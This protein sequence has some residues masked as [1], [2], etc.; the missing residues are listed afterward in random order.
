MKESE[1]KKEGE[2]K[3]NSEEKKK[4]ERKKEGKR[5]DKVSEECS[6]ENNS[7]REKQRAC[8]WYKSSPR[9]WFGGQ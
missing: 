3:A 4:T 9:I 6:E 1:V 5:L 8:A 2:K 7:A